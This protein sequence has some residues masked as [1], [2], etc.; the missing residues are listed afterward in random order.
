[1]H[2][3]ILG[4]EQLLR[5]HA[6][7]KFDDDI[8]LCDHCEIPHHNDCLI[9][10][11]NGRPNRYCNDCI[12]MLHGEDQVPNSQSSMNHSDLELSEQDSTSSGNSGDSDFK[13]ATKVAATPPID[14]ITPQN[15]ASKYSLRE[16]KKTK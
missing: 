10:D 5:C 15:T 16:R 4:V 3:Y 7:N 9:K 6:C 14:D 1:M 2:G 13:P 11:P 8:V 12:K